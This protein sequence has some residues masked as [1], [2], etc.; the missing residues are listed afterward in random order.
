MKSEIKTL[1]IVPH[2]FLEEI[3]DALLKL[4]KLT[5]KE[6]DQLP[7]ILSE[8]E[9]QKL[10][11][12]KTTWFFDMRKTGRLPYSKLGSKVFYKKEDLF[13]LMQKIS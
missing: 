13:N 8:K 5:D 4:L 9:A 10:L 3:K 6:K 2:E 12:R 1:A 7:D 11:G